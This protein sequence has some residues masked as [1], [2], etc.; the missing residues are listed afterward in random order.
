MISILYSDSAIW[1]WLHALPMSKPATGAELG[2][3]SNWIWWGAPEVLR[4]LQI[5]FDIVPRKQ[6]FSF[7]VIFQDFYLN[8]SDCSY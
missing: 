8:W 6:K 3:I 7:I 4:L 2:T 5:Q 1:G